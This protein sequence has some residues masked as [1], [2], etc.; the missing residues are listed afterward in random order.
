MFFFLLFSL[1][2]LGS[3]KAEY[4]E[5]FLEDNNII[6]ELTTQEYVALIRPFLPQN[7]IILE[8]GCHSGDD[9]VILTKSWPEGMVY[10]F[11]PVEKCVGFAHQ[12]L[13][14]N[15]VKNAKRFSLALSKIS[16]IQTFYY[17]TSIGAASSLLESNDLCDY[18]DI[19]LQVN[20]TNLDEWASTNKVNHIDFMWLDMEGNEYHVLN[21]APT[22]LK[23]VKVI[24]SEVNFRE[25]RKGTTQYIDLYNLLVNNGFKLYKIWGNLQWQGTAL[26]VR[27]D[28]L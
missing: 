6:N 14:R 28:L 17:S 2:T 15:N 24:I 8:A 25:F 20:G 5:S 3:Q 27:A 4:P 26:F 12:E 19:P 10:A 9:T 13:L 1:L 18:Q 11:E 21:S 23:T 22:I 7:P 16:G